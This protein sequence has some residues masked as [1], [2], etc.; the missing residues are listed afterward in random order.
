ME[1]WKIQ[2][3]KSFFV[4]GAGSSLMVNVLVKTTDNVTMDF[5]KVL[6]IQQEI[7]LTCR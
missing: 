1:I 6:V 7:I 3:E 2:G 4:F 5:V